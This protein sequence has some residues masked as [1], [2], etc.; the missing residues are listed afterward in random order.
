MAIVRWTPFELGTQSFDDLVRRTFGDF[1]SS[2]LAGRDQMTWTPPM[3]VY[4]DGEELHVRVE[5]PG[6]DPA[7]DVDL[8]VEDGTLRI[9]GERRQEQT[10]EQGGYYRREMR[11]GSF[12]RRIGLPDGV[13]A[14]SIRASYDAGILHV[15]VPVPQKVAKKVTVE[16]GSSNGSNN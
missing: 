14:D 11:S 13:E 1:G 3:D 5:L 2:L 9:S 7:S 8:E 10:S 6:I 15:T 12:E 4:L 16:I